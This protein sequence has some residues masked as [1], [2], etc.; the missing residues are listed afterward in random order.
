MLID[1]PN[2]H[3]PLQLV[4]KPNLL[5]SQLYLDHLWNNFKK[6]SKLLQQQLSWVPVHKAIRYYEDVDISAKTAANLPKQ[7]SVLDGSAILPADFSRF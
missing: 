3:P 1:L 6:K 7:S 2:H 4:G 5:E